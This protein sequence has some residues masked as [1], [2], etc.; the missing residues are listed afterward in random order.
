VDALAIGTSN[1]SNSRLNY[2]GVGVGD[3]AGAFR[4][5]P[6][7]IVD[8]VQDLVRKGWVTNRRSVEDRR[9][10]C[11]RL[12][13][14]GEALVRRIAPIVEGVEDMFSE[15]DKTILGLSRKGRN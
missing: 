11:L 1:A 12:S 4:V 5:E 8:V 3:T 2:S 6:P 9:V 13:P 7:T 15:E 14:K 10:V